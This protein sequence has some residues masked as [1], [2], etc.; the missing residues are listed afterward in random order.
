M[1]F[2][3]SLKLR[4][5]KIGLAAWVIMAAVAA[6][7]TGLFFGEYTAVL[8]PIGTIY[9]KMLQSVVYPYIIAS[10]LYGLGQLPSVTAKKLFLASWPFYIF[11][12]VLVYGAIWALNLAIGPAPAPNVFDAAALAAPRKS[13][14]NVVVP[15]NFFSDI[16][17]NNVPAVVI[18]AILFGV[19]LQSVSKKDTLLELLD[20]VRKASLTIWNWVVKLAP[21]AVFA[22][23]SV[24]AGTVDPGQVESLLLYLGLFFGG[25]LFLA[26][27]AFPLAISVFAPLSY[28]QVLSELK[29]GFIMAAVTTLSVAALP[30]ILNSINKITKTYCIPESESETISSTSIAVSY[31]LGQLGNYF[32]FFFI[33]FAISYF[34]VQVADQDHLTLLPI[35]LLSSFGSPSSTVN[36]VEFLTHWLNMPFEASVLYTQTMMFTRYG[37]ILLSVAGFGFLTIL[38]TLNYFGKLVFNPKR[39]FIFLISTLS[40]FI[41]FPIGMSKISTPGWNENKDRFMSL[42]LSQEI[43]KGVE[44]VVRHPPYSH[45]AIEMYKSP[46]NRVLSTGVLR[47]GYSPMIIP[48]CYFNS[49][50]ELVG[51][52]VAFAYSLAKSLGVN[53]EFIPADLPNMLNELKQEKYDILMSGIAFI[54][55][56]MKG[57]KYS[58]CYYA[59][60]LV[61]VVRD[62]DL[63][64]YSDYSILRD[65]K[66]LILAA[67]KDSILYGLSETLYPEAE[68][69][70]IKR[71]DDIVEKQEVKAMIWAWDQAAAWTE[72]HPEFSAI[73]PDGMNGV[74]AYGWLFPHR[75]DDLQIYVNHW[76]TLKKEDGFYQKKCDKW[77][78][79]KS[80]RTKSPRWSILN[81]ILRPQKEL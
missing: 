4:L 71:F 63:S 45:T 23:I 26:L 80:D 49:K 32:V 38:C 29:D 42:E 9:V 51:F 56:R 19:A 47:V 24:T 50:N 17:A 77:F 8:N 61:L 67:P 44:S 10:L 35:S 27:I 12:W 22:M 48:F 3:Y 16:A 21:V 81:N 15:A 11:A 53:L 75:T 1:S 60:P 74:L 31:P 79:G 37:Q 76:L 25:T 5:S 65:K 64:V 33:L 39:A 20:N 58:N 66:D 18:F 41:I 62:K 7:F 55:N 68:L 69:V 78:K 6:I 14:L 70:S 34:R 40:F 28:R 52:D 54:G 57:V 13:F 59:N 36:A 2:L 73:R 30:F 43:T 46:M 72:S